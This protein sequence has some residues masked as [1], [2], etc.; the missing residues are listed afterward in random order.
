VDSSTQEGQAADL[1][2]HTNQ[3]SS[4]GRI[5]NISAFGVDGSGELLIVDYSRGIVYRLMRVPG[6]PTNLRIIR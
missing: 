3:L 1:Q 4:T 6:S 2:E 5:G